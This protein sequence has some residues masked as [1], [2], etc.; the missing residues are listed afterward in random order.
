ME[1]ALLLF[2]QNGDKS[3]KSQFLLCSNALRVPKSILKK[4]TKGDKTFK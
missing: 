4:G 2:M 1:N 3:P